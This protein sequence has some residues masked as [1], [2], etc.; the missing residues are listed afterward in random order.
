MLAAAFCSF[1]SFKSDSRDA[2]VWGSSVCRDKDSRKQ[3]NATRREDNSS[4][5]ASVTSEPYTPGHPFPVLRSITDKVA[6]ML[7]RACLLPNDPLRER[8]M[9]PFKTGYSYQMATRQIYHELRTK[10]AQH[11]E[12]NITA[13]LKRFCFF[14]VYQRKR[15]LHFTMIEFLFK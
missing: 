4:N 12:A 8:E 5:S 9:N 13:I 14:H 1:V 6:H 10:Y 11:H 7:I 15:F 2:I 3:V